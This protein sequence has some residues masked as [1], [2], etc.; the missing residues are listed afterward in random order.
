MDNLHDRL[1]GVRVELTPY[2][3]ISTNVLVFASSYNTII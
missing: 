2:R 3:T 1:S